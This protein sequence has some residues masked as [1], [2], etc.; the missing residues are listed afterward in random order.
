MAYVYDTELYHSKGPWK[1]HKYKTKTDENGKTKYV[2][3]YGDYNKAYNKAN[4]KHKYYKNL[5]NEYHDLRKRND[6]LYKGHGAGNVSNKGPVQDVNYDEY[7]TSL[8]VN[9]LYKDNDKLLRDRQYKF[10]SEAVPYEDVI[11]NAKKAMTEKGA[12]A[13]L[14]RSMT[15]RK[16]NLI[17]KGKASLFNLFNKIDNRV[18]SI[19]KYN[20]AASSARKNKDKSALSD[21]KARRKLDK[22]QLKKT[23][24]TS[25]YWNERR[26]KG[27]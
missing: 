14:K 11:N 8:D 16:S 22:I 10:R 25:W 12:E 6:Y 1:K 4:A 19:K 26:K 5:E 2:Y 3:S 9:Q 17:N 27:K 24:S 13:K 15:E 21:A 23:G 7:E 20:T 18:Q